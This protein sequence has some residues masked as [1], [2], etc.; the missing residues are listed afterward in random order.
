MFCNGFYRILFSFA[1]LVFCEFSVPK[2]LHR[3][4]IIVRAKKVS[5]ALF[6]M[7]SSE[8]SRKNCSLC[9][10]SWKVW[11]FGTWVKSFQHVVERTRSSKLNK[12]HLFTSSSCSNIG[13]HFEGE[14]Y[15]DVA[16][17][18]HILELLCSVLLLCPQQ[19][20]RA[21]NSVATLACPSPTLLLGLICSFLGDHSWIRTN[22]HSTEHLCTCLSVYSSVLLGNVCVTRLFQPLISLSSCSW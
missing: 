21:Q 16:M 5:V 10:I 17:L 6:S 11:R 1:A 7:I 4:T 3:V 8:S 13:F 18:N 12:W 2:S 14:E 15:Q 22:D 19:R 9:L 20:W